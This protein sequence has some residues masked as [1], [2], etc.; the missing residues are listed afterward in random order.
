MPVVRMKNKSAQNIQSAD[1]LNDKGYFDSSVHCSYYG[2]LQIVKLT[3]CKI[4]K[5]DF[6]TQ[7]IESRASEIGSHGYYLKT[8]KDIFKTDPKH[9]HDR[10]L[11]IDINKHVNDILKLKELRVEA[12]YSPEHID[13]LKSTSAVSTAKSFSQ[14]MMDNFKL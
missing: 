9:K 1:L 12:D 4:G 7:A 3:I 13:P 5:I 8:F 10:K 11:N 2:C 6:G 14:F